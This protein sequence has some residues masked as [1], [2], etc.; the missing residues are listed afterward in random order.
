MMQ[1][2]VRTA[3]YGFVGRRLRKRLKRRGNDDDG[4]DAAGAS[5]GVGRGRGP[6]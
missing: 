5:A 4:V 1:T 2:E 3:R 6:G